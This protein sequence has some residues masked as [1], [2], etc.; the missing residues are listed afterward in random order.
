[1][2]LV[3]KYGQMVLNIKDNGK[4]IKHQ[5]KE[6]LYMKMVINIKVTGKMIKHMAMVFLYMRNPIPNIKVIGKMI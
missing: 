5:E 4:K 3:N 2:V 6:Y 1:M